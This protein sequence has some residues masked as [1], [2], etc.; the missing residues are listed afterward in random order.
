MQRLTPELLKKIQ[1]SGVPIVD[2][3]LEDFAKAEV[4]KPNK[5]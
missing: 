5:E 1:E 4:V 3:T 2:I